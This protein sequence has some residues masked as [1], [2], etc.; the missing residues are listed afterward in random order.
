VD[1]DYRQIKRIF[2]SAAS[3]QTNTGSLLLHNRLKLYTIT[4]FPLLILTN[5]GR[6]LKLPK[7]LFMHSP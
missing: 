5:R 7:L 4:F 2:A 1:G 3:A 6:G